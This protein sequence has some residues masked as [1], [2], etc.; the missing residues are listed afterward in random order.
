MKNALSI[1]LEDWYHPELVKNHLRRIPK[2]QIIESTQKII[3]LLDE[4]NVK[5]T[6]FILGD[7]IK[8]HPELIIH[9]CYN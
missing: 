8:K 1:D 3:A 9:S 5:A 7:I 6:F 2:S 4:Y